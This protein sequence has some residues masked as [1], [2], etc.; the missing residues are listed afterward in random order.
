MDWFSLCLDA[1]TIAIQSVLHIAFLCRLTER[2]PRPAYFAGY[3]LLLSGIQ[4]ICSAAGW[5]GV[6]A[7]GTGLLALYGI[8]RLALKNK[9]A[10]SWT[11]AVMAVY[12]YQLSFGAVN[13]LEAVAAPRLERGWQLYALVSLSALA[14]PV[15][16]GACYELVSRLLTLKEEAL[17]LLL[18][19]GLFLFAV[20]LYI[21]ETAYDGVPFSP[22]APGKHLALFFLQLLGLVALLCTLCAW[23]RACQGIRDRAALDTLTQSCRA[24][25]VYVAEARARYEKTKA[26]RHDLQNHLT[27]LNGLLCAGKTEEGCRYLQKLETAA[28]PLSPPCRTGSLEVDVM[29]GEKLAL[30]RS[31]GIEA[32]AFLR[33]PEGADG[34]DLCVIFANAMDNAVEA[35]LEVEGERFIRISGQRQGDFYR[36]EFENSCAPGPPPKPGTGLSNIK[37]VAEKYGGAVLAERSGG[38]FRLDVLLNISAR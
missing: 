34:F 32:E 4:G 18:L 17:E 24:Q 22:E 19:P 26:F 3:L 2:K 27:V 12:I 36:L 15:L 14:A 25:R 29:L 21:L 10:L 23:R 6:P 13:A 31:R 7:V 11:A 1:A 33:L 38:R 28:S 8:S 9:P 37:A 30:A 35:C 5:T 20:E 16:C